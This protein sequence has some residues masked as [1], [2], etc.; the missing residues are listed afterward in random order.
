MYII[1]AK[2]IGAAL[3]I[4]LAVVVYLIERAR[5][6]ELDADVL[7]AAEAAE[8]RGAR[9]LLHLRRTRL[10]AHLPDGLDDV[11]DAGG[12]VRVAEVA[13]S[14]VGVDGLVAVEGEASVDGVLPGL[15]ARHVADLLGHDDVAGHEEVVDEEQVDLVRGDAGELVGLLGA[16]DGAGLLVGERGAFVGCGA[17]AQDVDDL[18]VEATGDGHLGRH[19]HD[20]GS[21]VALGLEAGDAQ[22]LGD[23][24]VHHGG[25]ERSRR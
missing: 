24:G 10:A 19:E 5:A 18:V 2:N 20:G 3:G 13:A 4:P 21:A 22:V 1:E 11:G 8:Q 12:A 7:A 14:A 6:D 15:A 23:L 25:E 16:A 17:G 9:E